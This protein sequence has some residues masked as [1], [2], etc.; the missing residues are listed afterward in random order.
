MFGAGR[1][2]GALLFSLKPDAPWRASMLRRAGCLRSWGL[3][4]GHA[5]DGGVARSGQH[6]PGR[7]LTIRPK[8]R[9]LAWDSVSEREDAEV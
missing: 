4:S 9:I 5:P 7:L 3:E 2:A 1:D 6:A 8:G